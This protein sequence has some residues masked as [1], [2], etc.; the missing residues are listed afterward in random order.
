MAA[1]CRSGRRRSSG[2]VRREIRREDAL[3]IASRGSRQLRDVRGVAGGRCH[4]RQLPTGASRV[5]A[6][7]DSC[8]TRGIN[9]PNCNWKQEIVQR[10]GEV[11]PS[12]L[13]ELAL[14]LESRYAELGSYDAVMAE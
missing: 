2:V 10:V 11:E 6:R 7:S 14:H 9:M 3:R 4:C 5:A 1:R 13:E 12:I 8:V